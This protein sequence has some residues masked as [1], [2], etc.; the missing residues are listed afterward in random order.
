MAQNSI[1]I[2]DDVI[3]FEHKL[4]PLYEFLDQNQMNY[5]KFA[6]SDGDGV[7]VIRIGEGG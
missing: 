4:T 1:I 7:I 6:L 3:E 2:C 5:E